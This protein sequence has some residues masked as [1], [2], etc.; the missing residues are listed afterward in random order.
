MIGQLTKY[1]DY[2]CTECGGTGKNPKKRTR[3]CASCN[4]IGKELVCSNCLNKM[5]CGGVPENVI[6]GGCERRKHGK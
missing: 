2:A 3:T 6:D 4:G 5:P 1:T